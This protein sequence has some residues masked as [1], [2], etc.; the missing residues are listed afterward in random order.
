V[1][2]PRAAATPPVGRLG[3]PVLRALDA[4][5]EASDRVLAE[6]Y[7]GAAVR[8]QPVHTVYLPA[9][10]ADART[11]AAWGAA[12]VALLTSALPNPATAAAITGLEPVLDDQVYGRVQAKLRRQPVEDLRI[13]F[14]DGYGQRDEAEEDAAAAAAGRALAEVL[15]DPVGPFVA[16]IRV[17][18]LEASTRARGVR[19]FD[20]V[21]GA[22]LATGSWPEGF[23]VTMPKV[24]SVDQV[25][26]LVDVCSRLEQAYGLPARTL[27]FEIQI[28]LPQAILGPD[29]T[30][31]VAPMIHAADGRCAGLHYGTFDY[32][33]ACGIAPAAQS[34]D[35]PVADHAKA[36][37]QV[38]AAGTGVPLSDG[39]TNVLPVGT[40]EEVQRAVAR[41]AGLV[42]RSLERGYY[43]GWD[44][45]PGHLVS[46]YLATYTFYRAGRPSAVD[47]LRLYLAHAEQG[48]RDEPATAEALARFLLRGLDCGALDD[49][50]TGVGLDR[51]GLDALARRRPVIRAP[52]PPPP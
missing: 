1:I 37:M 33:A 50:D 35:H 32:S 20:I 48:V 9:D 21:V 10:Q 26:A 3:Q 19:T 43:Q 14:E 16:G 15:A 25:A 27:R 52:D 11:P 38:A 36:V 4:R 39:S 42:S 2:R 23:V 8:R 51:R 40:D 45:H 29:G 49:G 47:R 6:R 34:V 22:I 18:S 30:A 24:T 28:E 44:L 5:L 13:D 7:S 31:T 41:H 46:R 17:K 12:A